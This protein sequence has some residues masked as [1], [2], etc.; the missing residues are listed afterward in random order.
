MKLWVLTIVMIH[1][2]TIYGYK[3]LKK[4][5]CHRIGKELTSVFKKSTYTCKEKQFPIDTKDK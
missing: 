5:N 3:F 2:K 1:G 4:E